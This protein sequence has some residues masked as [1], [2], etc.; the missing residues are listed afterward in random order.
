MWACHVNHVLVK[1]TFISGRAS[2]VGL[3]PTSGQFATMQHVFTKFRD[4]LG[5]KVN[6]VIPPRHRRQK[7]GVQVVANE[8]RR[9]LR[10]NQH[11]IREQ[12]PTLP[13]ILC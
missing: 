9:C 1:E 3:A 8:R 11:P 7:I 5:F 12:P 13:Q 6:R 2:S 10:I 4:L